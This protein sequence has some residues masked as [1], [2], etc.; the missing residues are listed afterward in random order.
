ML[1]TYI[2]NKDKVSKYFPEV[3]DT[4]S[5]A[6]N[7]VD[8]SD[9]VR[10]QSNRWIDIE[11][12]DRYIPFCFKTEKAL[13][14]DH[15]QLL[16]KYIES[17]SD[18][19]GVFL[20][21]VRKLGSDSCEYRCLL[22][23]ISPPDSSPSG[24]NVL[25]VTEKNSYELKEKLSLLEKGCYFL[26]TD[27]NCGNAYDESKEL[28]GMWYVPFSDNLKLDKYTVPNHSLASKIMGIPCQDGVFHS[29]NDTQKSMIKDIGDKKLPSI[30]VDKRKLIGLVDR[31]LKTEDPLYTPV[32]LKESLRDGKIHFYDKEA[33]FKILS[34]VES[35]DVSTAITSEPV[36]PIMALRENEV[37][38]V[39]SGNNYNELY[40]I[41][42]LKGDENLNKIG[43]S[44]NDMVLEGCKNYHE[45]FK[46]SDLCKLDTIII[47]S[48]GVCAEEGDIIYKNPGTG[49]ILPFDLIHSFNT[50]KN[51]L[52]V[53]IK[54]YN[55]HREVNITIPMEVDVDIIDDCH[56]SI[57]I[58]TS[59][60]EVFICE[61]L[62]MKHRPGEVELL[63]Q[64]IK[65]MWKKGY[66]FNNYGLACAHHHKKYELGC[67]Q[68]PWWFLPEREESGEV[69]TQ[70]MIRFI[71]GI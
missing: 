42:F 34:E 40:E 33:F 57:T 54:G 5:T 16:I 69:R 22:T 1:H 2:L 56:V 19:E 7:L 12:T 4:S 64:I 10:I 46:H 53:R 21:L 31:L 66:F 60:E 70:N 41:I 47:D 27:P 11:E 32:K 65:K 14:S 6:D 35:D 63:K 39:M 49:K 67:I 15:E 9:L 30:K 52:D 51:G 59:K 62:N 55:P 50:Y 26:G 37:P 3:G 71:S 29:L 18:T 48:H 13:D 23:P 68:K 24:G 8:S 43:F 17:M 45:V 28:N 38:Y 36:D 44:I 61:N 20:I 25:Y 58:R